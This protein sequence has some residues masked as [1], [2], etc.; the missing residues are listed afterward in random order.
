LVSDIQNWANQ[1]KLALWVTAT[2]EFGRH[3]SPF[4][5]SA[6]EELLIIPNKGAIGLLTTG[7]P[8]FS[9]VNFSL[10]EAFMTTVFEQENG[11]YQDLGSI[12]KTTKNQSLNGPLN[13]NFSL[14]GDPSLRLATPE[15]SIE[16]TSFKN[17]ETGKDLDT[18]SIYQVMEFEAEVINPF[19][20]SIVTNFE[21]DYK[22]ELRDKPQK[23]TTLG[24]ES[25]PVSFKD[26]SVLLFQGTGRI[27]SGKMKGELIIPKNSGP[28]FG[29]GR[30]RII[31][32][33][34]TS[35]LEAYGHSNPL[36]GGELTQKPLDGT[37]PT[38]APV[39]GEKDNPQFTFA[40]TTIPLFV[41]YSDESGINV[42]NLKST[43]L[44]QVQVNDN[45]PQLLNQLFFTESGS[46]KRGTVEL[47]LAG[48]KE[49]KNKVVFMAWD[50]V[51][52]SSILEQEIQVEGSQRIQIT[53]HLTFPNPTESE[54]NFIIEHNM[55]GKNL[56]M[57]LSIYT[58]K[59]QIL[60]SKSDR[61]VKADALVEGLTWIFSKS[62]TKY[63]A[64]GTY[65]YI[66]TL[67]SETDNSSDTVSGKIVIQ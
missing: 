21:G 10:N 66:L 7:R 56:L 12:F 59:G 33:E 40:S 48:F 57:T 61:L 37:G 19:N 3:D 43:E 24:D 44:L 13:R 8:V 25:T 28:E 5:R 42:S 53:R 20:N 55:P 15:L 60:F 11:I 54:S 38:I 58:L 4:I 50:N 52:N 67:Q 63:P 2:C 22:V 16:F 46:Y 62:Q 41:A 45:K 23:I 18:L 51:G 39:F 34:K 47:N 35:L 9:S 27:S 65:I 32:K 14:L 29:K 36:I 49:G 30:F 6:A 26:E 1:E 31:G 64:K 17:P